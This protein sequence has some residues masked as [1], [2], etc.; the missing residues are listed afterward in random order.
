M[1]N[2]SGSVLRR[3][4]RTTSPRAPVSTHIACA[5]PYS[6]QPASQ[7]APVPSNPRWLSDVKHRIGHCITFGLT[8]SQN[9]EAFE[10]IRD[11][12]VSWRELLA[13]SE[14]FL[15]GKHRRSMFRLPVV[16]GEQ[17]SM[18]HVNNVVYNRYAETGRIGW[19]SKYGRYIDPEHAEDWN[20]L[21]TPK[22]E[23]LILRKITTE[24]KFPM[25]YPDHVT[26]YHRLGTKPAEGT[27]TFDLHVIILSELHQRPAARVV[28]DCVLYDYIKRKKTPIQP[29]ML[30]VLRETWRLQEITKRENSERVS[31]LLD[32]VRQLELQ[33]WDRA[34]AVE[35]MGSAGS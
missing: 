14:G 7:P 35:Y 27:D 2:I 17:D 26:I 18:G 21:W 34:D 11:F 16:W 15:T 10:I 29:F 1:A 31:S 33:S 25:T 13:G 6:I 19:A 4:A 9:L 23:G 28:E 8:P 12:A 5:K 22:G 24:F 32:R 30:E 3:A 20:G